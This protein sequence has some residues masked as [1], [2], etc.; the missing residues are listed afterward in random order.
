MISGEFQKLFSQ[1]YERIGWNSI[2]G[3]GYADDSISHFPSNKWNADPVFDD[4]LDGLKPAIWISTGGDG[5]NKDN[6]VIG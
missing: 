5:I 6:K 2:I 4:F 1:D 3:A